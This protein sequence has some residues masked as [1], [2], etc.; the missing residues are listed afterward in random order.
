MS[1]RVRVTVR[2]LS[3]TS[4]GS[5]GGNDALRCGRVVA[6]KEKLVLH[7][8]RSIFCAVTVERT[9]IRLWLGARPKPGRALNRK[10]V[11][12]CLLPGHSKF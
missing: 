12:G 1:E 6:R 5:P 10:R 4:R 8:G 2:D 11:I 9:R 3:S 7:V